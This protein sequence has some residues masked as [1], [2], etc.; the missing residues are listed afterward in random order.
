[1]NFR[2]RPLAAAIMIAFS[3]SGALAQS[4]SEQ[5]LP[6]VKVRGMQDRYRTESSTTATRTDTPLRDVPQTVTVL[7]KELLQQQNAVTLQDALRNVTGITFFAGEGGQMGDGPRLRGFDARGSIF[8]DGIRDQG[9]YFRD[10]FNLESIEVLKGASSLL[11]GRGSP[12][13][14]VNQVTKAPGLA[15]RNEASVT[16][17]SHDFKRA[18]ADLNVP[19]GETTAVRLNAMIQDN[20]SHRDYVENARFGFAP[21]VRF[22][23]NTPT[24]VTLSYQYLRTRDVPDYGIVH[25]FGRPAPVDP[26]NFYGF[27]TRD[28]DHLDTHIATLRVDHRFSEAL[29]LRNT[30]AWAKYERDNE[31]TAPRLRTGGAAPTP[32]TPLAAITVRRNDRKSRLEDNDSLVNQTEAVWK[33]MTG[34][35]GHTLLAGVELARERID[36]TTY[37]FPGLTETSHLVSLLDPD[38][39]NEGAGW[40]KT[41]QAVLRTEATT[42]ALYLQDQLRLSPQWKAVAG[43]RWDRFEVEHDNNQIVATAS[44]PVG[45]TSLSRTDKVASTRGGLIWQP[46]AS[47]S[48]YV[49]YGTAFSPSAE[50]GTLANNT[51]NVEPEKVRSYEA[52]AKLEITRRVSVSAALFRNE[53]TNER[54]ADPA[55]GPDQVLE[56]ARRIDGVELG[57]AGRITPAWDVFA[58][59]VLMDARITKQPSTPANVG[60]QPAFVAEKA[61]NL[62]STWRFA[63]NW[64]LGGGFYRIGSYFANDTNATLVPGYTRWDATLAYVQP[65]YEVRLNLQNVFDETYYESAHPSHVKPGIPRQLFATLV[66]RF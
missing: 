65:R 46:T 14:V 36:R 53:K 56:G 55:G 29:S 31:I 40:N 64:E 7:P 2:R 23:I 32:G 63:E 15:A 25:L 9:E 37:T 47:Q 49:S 18:T 35:I 11:Y 60:N 39:A 24:E 45:V 26:S 10:T 6:E 12:S 1:M 59:A 57:I 27:P 62:W 22:G 44:T 8:V 58:G 3:S 61:A 66:Y 48:Y 43:V 52:G 19:L 13:G 30:L 54:V 33:T 42:R 50:F 20:E 4:A 5:T 34:S 38:P 17:G 16:Y 28:Y 21:S 51:V 41:P